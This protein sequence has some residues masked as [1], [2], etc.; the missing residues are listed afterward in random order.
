MPRLATAVTAW[1]GWTTIGKRRLSYTLEFFVQVTSTKNTCTEKSFCARSGLF[2]QS[3]SHI[4]LWTKKNS[5]T[6]AIDLPF[7]TFAV[8]LLVEF[9]D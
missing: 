6:L 7:L 2:S 9:I 3:R 4:C 1:S 5:R 8:G